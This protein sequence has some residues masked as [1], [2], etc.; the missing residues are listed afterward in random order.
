MRHAE[1]DHVDMNIWCGKA[2]ILEIDKEWGFE[3]TGT[4]RSHR[5]SPEFPGVGRPPP[6][7]TIESGLGTSQS[8]FL[9]PKIENV[10]DNECETLKKHVFSNIYCFCCVLNMIFF[11]FI[12]FH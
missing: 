12:D 4:H 8:Q 3:N 1:I 7:K 11:I 10:K 5:S 6:S 2:G 9:R